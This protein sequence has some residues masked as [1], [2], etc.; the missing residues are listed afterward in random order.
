MFQAPQQRGTGSA[1]NPSPSPGG[2]SSRF[3]VPGRTADRPEA[4][5][6]TPRPRGSAPEEAA[7]LGNYATAGVSPGAGRERARPRKTPAAPGQGPPTPPTPPL[8][9]RPANHSRPGSP[10]PTLPTPNRRAEKAGPRRTRRRQ[11]I[12]PLISAAAAAGHRSPPCR[13]VPCRTVPRRPPFSAQHHFLIRARR[14]ARA[15]RAPDPRN[16]CAV[17]AAVASP[18]PTAAPL[19][20]APP[21]PPSLSRG[22]AHRDRQSERGWPGPL[23]LT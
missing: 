6:L 19:R 13:A 1:P 17:V 12:V 20:P 11:R 18:P 2:R 4:T 23:L 9:P 22:P 15:D 21:R 5:T 3:F 7:A 14:S 8:P 10:G 16:R